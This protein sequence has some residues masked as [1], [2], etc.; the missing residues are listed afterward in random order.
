MKKYLLQLRGYHIILS[1]L[2]LFGMLITDAGNVWS[3]QPTKPHVPMLSL[4][5]A[6]TGYSKDWYPDGRIWMPVGETSLPREFLLP[7]FVQNQWHHYTGPGSKA[8]YLPKPITSFEFNI[9]FDSLA[10]KPMGIVKHHPFPDTNDNRVRMIGNTGSDYFY[11]PYASNFNITWDEFK[12]PYYQLDL[13]TATTLQ[14]RSRG[15]GIR[16]TGTSLIPLAIT[17][18][19]NEEYVVLFYVRFRINQY[20]NFFNRE[21]GN[22]PIYISSRY[23]GDDHKI[24]IDSIRF[25]DMIVNI[26]APFKEYRNYPDYPYVAVDYPDP[27]DATVL[28]GMD[29]SILSNWNTEP[30]LPG[31]IALRLTEQLPQFG[32]R[33]ER[34]VGQVPAIV[35]LL[36]E[37]WVMQD[38]ITVDSGKVVK[39]A[40][41]NTIGVGSRTYQLLNTVASSRMNDIYIQTDQPWLLVRIHSA[42]GKYTPDKDITKAYVKW[43]DNIMGCSSPTDCW[44]DQMLVPT[45]KDAD[46]FVEIKC[47]PDKIVNS[48]Y[49]NNGGEKAG[50]YV[51]HV[52][53]SSYCA[54]ISP[55]RLQVS[56]INFRDPFEP[57][58]YE[59]NGLYTDLHQGIRLNITSHNPVDPRMTRLVFGTGH[60]ASDGV[61][62]LFGEKLA[63]HTLGNYSSKTG[64]FEARWYLPDS[65]KRQLIAPEGFGDFFPNDEFQQT[66]VIFTDLSGPTPVYDTIPNTGS[67]DIRDIHDTS[68]SIIYFCRFINNS[69]VTIDWDTQ[70]FPT[71]AILFLSDTANG[72]IFPSIN[73]REA[74]YLGGTRYSYYIDDPKVTSFKIEYT[75]PRIIQYLDA[76]GNPIIHKG[77][78][79]LS[80]PVRPRNTKWFVFYPNAMNIPYYYSHEG[81]YQFTEDLTPGIGYFIKYSDV[82]DK[83]FTGVFMKRITV[84]PADDGFSDKVIIYPGWNT[85]GSLSYPMNIR[86]ID[87]DE[88]P[89]YPGELP[90]KIYLRQYGVWGYQTDKGYYEVSVIEP[91]LGYWIKSDK[92]GY[93]KLISDYAK[94]IVND[95]NSKPD[96]LAKST[97]LIIRDNSMH[98][99]N[100]YMLP[101]KEA[102]VSSF[103]LPPLP[104]IGLF[105]VR[106]NNNRYVNNTDVSVISLQGITYPMSINIDYSDANYTFYDAVTNEVLGSIQ[107]G[108]AGNVEVFGTKGNAIKVLKVDN[109]NGN[110]SMISQPNPVENSST[111]V[112]T[113]PDNGNVTIK[114]YD[115]IG[116][117]VATVADSY[118]SAGEHTVSLNAVNLSAGRYLCKLI[119][120]SH[121]EV[122]SIS[123]VK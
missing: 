5:G 51:G 73:M 7:V 83:T 94:D 107:K 41:G 28:G 29:N 102:D 19:V 13:D 93:L 22:T 81:G 57:P 67:R 92:H 70:D 32:Y 9:L 48:P 110:Y 119:Q 114:L 86:N 33:L 4:T 97:K 39:D 65:A 46:V 6:T 52:T 8:I 14:V 34:G 11:E 25:N 15:H 20:V 121:T 112:Y 18:T 87:F 36:N 104:P 106:Y 69:P 35:P 3:Q 116:N 37:Y 60:R 56:F 1:V 115:A 118:V 24:H 74:T 122:L 30:I 99:G 53:M 117:E 100:L 43:M 47:D 2:L 40:G 42:R 98:E 64:L 82:V 23:P 45:T 105:D 76:Y 71:D 62:S 88:N 78:N 96:V 80:L 85:V 12:A 21:V 75:L 109:L 59:A 38:P 101:D 103:E 123:V 55:V 17:D 95:D 27:S 58:L 50:V 54:Q 111:I 68:E 66:G 108:T 77:W 90:S 26:D 16:V 44:N 79:L 120:G 31:M 10:I 49:G 61:D 72:Q 91:G 89:S 84:S 63:D 113:V